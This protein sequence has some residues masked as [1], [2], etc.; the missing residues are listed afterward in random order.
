MLLDRGWQYQS[1]KLHEDIDNLLLLWE[2]SNLVHIVVGKEWITVPIAVAE[3]QRYHRSGSHRAK[4]LQLRVQGAMVNIVRRL[5]A[6]HVLGTLGEHTNE[7]HVG[8]IVTD[9]IAVDERRVAQ[10]GGFFPKYSSILV[11]WRITSSLKLA[12]LTR[13]A[14]P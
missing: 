14:S 13:E 2:G 4:E 9:I 11:H 7:S 8:N 5:P 10:Y 6:E 1:R 3:A 12:S